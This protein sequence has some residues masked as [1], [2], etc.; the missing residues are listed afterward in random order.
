MSWNTTTAKQKSK[1]S[2]RSHGPFWRWYL[3]PPSSLCYKSSTRY[4]EL[5]TSVFP[6][7]EWFFAL[8]LWPLKWRFWHTQFHTIYNG[9][10]NFTDFQNIFLMCWIKHFVYWELFTTVPQFHP[11]LVFPLKI[12]IRPTPFVFPYQKPKNLVMPPITGKNIMKHIICETTKANIA[13]LG[14]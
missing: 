12:P 10:N 13:N 6:I 9:S 4:S 5:V 1:L 11:R 8:S 2:F 7:S 14:G 3:S